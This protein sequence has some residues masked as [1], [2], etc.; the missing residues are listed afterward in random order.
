MLGDILIESLN[1]DQINHLARDVDPSFNLAAISGF[2]EKISVPRKVAVDCV[3][4]FFRTEESL[5]RFIGYAISRDGHGMSGGVVQLR[6]SGELIRLLSEMNW[7]YSPDKH[8]FLK[9]QSR[10]RTSDWGFL[11]KGEEYFHSF[12]SIDIVSSS[13]LVE[14]NV[15]GDVTT[16]FSNLRNYINQYVEAANGR[17][18]F[19]HGDG[20]LAT[21]FGDECVPQSVQAIVSILSYLPVFNIA[22]NELRPENDVKLRC[23][24]HCGTAIYDPQISNIAS[25]DMQLAQAVEKHCA[26]ANQVAITQTALFH[27]R[28]EMRALFREDSEFQGLKIFTFA[29]Q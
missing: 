25:P 19:W 5:V 2:G 7:I 21:F 14:T 28:P 27:L 17:I 8:V 3:L 18:W 15:K 26:A 22:Q 29:P 9:D 24:L 13:M 10:V 1:T 11:Q 20:G 12:V 23:G 6:R 4:R 16:T